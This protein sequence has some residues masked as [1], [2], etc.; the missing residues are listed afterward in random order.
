MGDDSAAHAFDASLTHAI[1]RC[2]VPLCVG[3]DPVVDRLPQPCRQHEP[4]EAVRRFG[5]SV[6]D[7]VAPHAAAIKAQSACYER[8][9]A[10]GPGVLAEHIAAAR[11][12]GLAVILDAKRGDIGTTAG[13]Y[14]AAAVGLG[15]QAITVSPYMGMETIAP[16]LDAGLAVFVLVRTSNP[17]AWDLQDRALADGDTLAQRVARLVAE[18]GRQRPGVHAVVGA[19]RTDDA[20]SLRAIMPRQVL[21]LPGLG[22]QGATPADVRAFLG[23]ATPCAGSRGVLPTASRSVLYA[24]DGPAWADAVAAAAGALADQLTRAI[25]AP[26]RPA[27]GRA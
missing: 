3:L 13:H 11:R 14:A 19:T 7:A 8:L 26:D 24:G 16:Y 23:D 18:L 17:G 20:T 25:T 22:S 10:G 27:P 12:H 2:G 15:A 1:A 21:L 5:L 9:G 4:A 6:I